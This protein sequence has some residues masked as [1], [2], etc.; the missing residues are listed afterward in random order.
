MDLHDFFTLTPMSL[1]DKCHLKKFSSTLQIRQAYK[2]CMSHIKKMAVAE[3]SSAALEQELREID[4]SLGLAGREHRI[5][6]D[7]YLT[8]DYFQRQVAYAQERI[9]QRKADFRGMG[10]PI[11]MERDSPILDDVQEKLNNM[12]GNAGFAPEWISLDKEIRQSIENIKKRLSACWS[13]CGPHPMT[14][15]RKKEWEQELE[16]LSHTV[17]TINEKITNL[18][19]IVPTLSAQRMHIRLELLVSRVIAT[20][21]FKVNNS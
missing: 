5:P 19:L 7:I 2:N 20:K 13:K 11:R 16:E 3:E 1:Y 8:Q 14:P 9:S 12:M 6:E 10:K 17:K 21:P 18:N 4:Q 15:E